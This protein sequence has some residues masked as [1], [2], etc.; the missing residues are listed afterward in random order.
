MQSFYGGQIMIDILT[1]HTL[2]HVNMSIR[3][4]TLSHL[5][6]YTLISVDATR[7]KYWDGR[8]CLRV[9]L[10]IQKRKN[11]DQFPIPLKIY[12]GGNVRER[13]T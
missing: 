5:S 10:S 11:E 1:V 2:S 12:S 3:R 8:K 13:N 9:Q 7:K 4:N 6:I